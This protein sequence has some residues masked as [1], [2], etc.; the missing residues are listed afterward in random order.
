MSALDIARAYLLRGWHP[1][2]IPRGKKSPID[3]EWQ[4]RAITPENVAQYF[5]GGA[6]NVGVLM[7]PKS[8]GLA[9]V[10]LD[11]AEARRLAFLL[12]ETGAVFGRESNPSSHHLYVV[13]DAKPVTVIK[14]TDE[15][16]KTI[17]ELRLGAKPGAGAQTVFPG[18][19]HPSGEMIEW[20]KD[21]EPAVVP[22]TA[23]VRAVRGIAIASVLLRHWPYMP[24][25]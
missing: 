8:G 3:K 15:N 21:G 12:P 17:L 11:C 24:F 16:G 4:L 5:N 13:S 7:G 1:V 9:D 22:C 20:V 14:H 2:A 25:R 23:L 19:Q 18:S 6:L 10:D